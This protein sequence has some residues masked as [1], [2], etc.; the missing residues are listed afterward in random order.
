MTIEDQHCEAFANWLEVNKLK[1]THIANENSM[2]WV[3]SKSAMIA[4]AR[5]KRIGLRKGIPDFVVLT[6]KGVVWVEMKDPKKKLKQG[7][8]I[9]GWTENQKERGGL[10]RE[11]YEWILAIN[12]TPGTQAQVCYGADE[13]VKFISKFI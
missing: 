11:Q 10:K 5:A 1:F 8:A 2:S 7:D 3:D 4:G 12:K 13:A 6:P 9:E